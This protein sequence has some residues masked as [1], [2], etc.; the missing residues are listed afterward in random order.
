[1][2][3][4]LR[5]SAV[6]TMGELVAAARISIVAFLCHVGASAS[7]SGHSTTRIGIKTFCNGSDTTHLLAGPITLIFHC[8]PAK[9]I[10]TFLQKNSAF[11]WQ[12]LCWSI[13]FLMNINSYSL[14]NTEYQWLNWWTQLVSSLL[15]IPYDSFDLYLREFLLF[16]TTEE[17]VAW[18]RVRRETFRESSRARA[19]RLWATNIGCNCDWSCST[20]DLSN[21]I[22][23]FIVRF[24]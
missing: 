8:V 18:W 5:T 13:L 15:K 3:S 23:K 17:F 22:V 1:M 20:I 10:G 14:S 12:W 7:G 11:H 21:W 4:F 2:L 6:E 24:V 16:D 19:F 9:A